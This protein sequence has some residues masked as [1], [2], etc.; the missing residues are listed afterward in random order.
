[1]ADPPQRKREL[2]DL[3]LRCQGRLLARIRWMLGE[4]ARQTAESGDFLAQVS[5]TVLQQGDDLRWNDESHFLNLA[6]RI[7]RHQLI[8]RTRRHHH[9]ERRLASFTASLCLEDPGAATP[10][11]V[12]EL[13]EQV[14]RLLGALEQLPANYQRVIELRHFEGLTFADIAE[15]L[16]G[17]DNSV[18]ILHRRALARLAVL[19]ERPAG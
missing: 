8:D 15:Q 19:L 7:A 11:D 4:G 18:E 13:G 5:M 2:D 9:R 17:T 16:E 1:M 10:S 14:D 6:T 3:L 12:L